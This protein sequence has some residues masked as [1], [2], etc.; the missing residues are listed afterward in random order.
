LLAT[1]SALENVA[2]PLRIDNMPR[3]LAHQRAS[4]ALA[5]VNLKS[6]ASHLPH[7]MSGGEQQRVAVARALVTSPAV[8][9]ADEP[10]GALDSENGRQIWQLLQE[11]SR[12]GQT[13]VVVTHDAELA[14]QSDRILH[15]RDGVILSE[16]SGR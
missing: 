10:T 6:R 16:T 1:L 13:V 9:F 3:Q 7:E 15:M 5:D 4:E 12:R 14:K 11:R 8:L 2:L